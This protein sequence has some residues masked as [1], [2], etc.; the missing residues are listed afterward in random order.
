MVIADRMLVLA[1]ASRTT[2]A[3]AGAT[4]YSVGIAGEPGKFGNLLGI[5]KGSTNIGVIGPTA[6][7]APAPIRITANG[8]GFTGGKVR[9]ALHAM[10]LASP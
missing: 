5:A 10:S 7:Y 6:F 1:V 8:E 4:S 9:L 3:I 2:E